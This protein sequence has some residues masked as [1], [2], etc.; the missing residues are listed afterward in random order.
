MRVG[1]SKLT[2][3]NAPIWVEL[4]G[5]GVRSG[6]FYGRSFGEGSG[7]DKSIGGGSRTETGIG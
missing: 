2:A 4:G 7:H 1:L 5:V 6:G 3:A